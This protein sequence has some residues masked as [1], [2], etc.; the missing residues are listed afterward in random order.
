MNLRVF[1]RDG[2]EVI[3]PLDDI[4]HVEFGTSAYSGEHGT[5][6]DSPCPLIVIFFRDGRTTTFT[7]KWLFE[8]V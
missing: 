8:F 1:T 7:S 5:Y 2:N 6:V 4:R 3:Y